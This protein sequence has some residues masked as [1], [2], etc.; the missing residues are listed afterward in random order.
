VVS[1]ESERSLTLRMD[2]YGDGREIMKRPPMRVHLARVKFLVSF[3]FFF[4]R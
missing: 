4:A 1:D 3:L 2:W